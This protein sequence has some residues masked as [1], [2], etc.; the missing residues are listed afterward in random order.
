[1]GVLKKQPD[2][3]ILGVV[4]NLLVKNTS[5]YYNKYMGNYNKSASRQSDELF[6][7]GGCNAKI[8][9]GVLSGLLKALPQDF[10]RRIIGRLRQL[11]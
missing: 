5:I 7:C 8:G 11:R 1:M 2:A 9:A 10:T 6:V 4:G 3:F